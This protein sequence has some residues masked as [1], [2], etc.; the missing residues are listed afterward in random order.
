MHAKIYCMLLKNKG[1]R[2]FSRHHYFVPEKLELYFS[3]D[4]ESK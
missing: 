3:W 1:F 2:V 4:G